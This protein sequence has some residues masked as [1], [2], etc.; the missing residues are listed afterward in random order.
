MVMHDQIALAPHGYEKETI[1]TKK[2]NVYFAYMRHNLNMR[3]PAE[4]R[5]TELRLPLTELEDFIKMEWELK[6]L[7]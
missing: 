1:V 6:P 5:S 3:L 7:K 4:Q 2:A